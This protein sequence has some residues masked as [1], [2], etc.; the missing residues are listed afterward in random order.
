MRNRKHL[1]KL[2]SFDLE[3]LALS[4]GLEKAPRIRSL[5]KQNK[6]KRAKLE[7][8]IPKISDNP[9]VES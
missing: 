4:Y 3:A 9:T 2:E 5:E 6:V 8:E 1:F 7:P